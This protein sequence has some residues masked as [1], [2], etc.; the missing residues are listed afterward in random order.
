VGLP[1]PPRTPKTPNLSAAPSEDP[2]LGPEEEEVE[3]ELEAGPAESDSVDEG[4]GDKAPGSPNFNGGS[5]S[6]AGE[7]TGQSN[8]L[9]KAGIGTNRM[10][11]KSEGEKVPTGEVVGIL[12]RALRDYV[13]CL[14]KDDEE[15]LGES[16][17]TASVFSA[18]LSSASCSAS[19]IAPDQV[20]AY[21]HCRLEFEAQEK[22]IEGTPSLMVEY[23]QKCCSALS[24]LFAVSFSVNT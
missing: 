12:Q 18:S 14:Q 23:Y 2:I 11:G 21:R 24:F 9:P 22:F 1:R 20:L 17:G 6:P 19:S 3:A 4:P 8:G 13:A 16:S 7:T 5:E 15:S 10:G